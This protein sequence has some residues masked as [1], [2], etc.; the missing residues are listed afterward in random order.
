MPERDVWKAA[1][2][3]FS[4]EG[5]LVRVEAKSRA[6]FVDV[7]ACVGGVTHFVELKHVVQDLTDDI[8]RATFPYGLK[9]SQAIELARWAAAGAPSWLVVGFGSPPR[10][11]LGFR[12]SRVIAMI[13]EQRAVRRGSETMRLFAFAADGN[14]PWDRII[15]RLDV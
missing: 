6:G 1:K 10:Q 8:A 4:Y 11:Y 12:G 3:G 14:F 9:G 7:M 5:R 13:A 2:R 15:G